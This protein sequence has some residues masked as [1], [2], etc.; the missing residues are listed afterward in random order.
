MG[1]GWGRKRSEG[2]EIFVGALVWGE[3]ES[4]FGGIEPKESGESGV[5]WGL[6]GVSL[7][8][9]EGTVRCLVSVAHHLW[10][11]STLYELLKMILYDLFYT[12]SLCVYSSV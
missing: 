6:Y 10:A 9:L 1:E 4:C 5:I 2:I 3:L 11:P 7:G 8:R 12:Y